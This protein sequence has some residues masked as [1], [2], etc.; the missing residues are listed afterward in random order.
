MVAVNKAS[1]NGATKTSSHG[2]GVAAPNNTNT[3]TTV[4][5]ISTKP[6]P[7]GITDLFLTK[8]TYQH[9][10]NDFHLF[11]QHDF[12]CLIHYFTTTLGVWG[13]MHLM[14]DLLNRHYTSTAT[15]T[16]DV[17]LYA[18]YAYMILI[19][20]TTPIM[21]AVIH[22]AMIYGCLQ[23][24]P[25][26][27]LTYVT[28]KYGTQLL[29]L[30]N[31]TVE[32][33]HIAIA[34]IVL[35]YG[36]QDLSHYLCDEPTFMS[37]YMKQGK[38]WMLIVH[39]IWLLPLVIDSILMRHCYLPYLVTRNRNVV[40][41]S[42]ASRD[43]VEGLRDW[44]H[45]N[46]P[47]TPETTHVWPHNQVP[48]SK[49]TVALENDAAI[50]AA[51]RTVF[52]KKHYD[53]VPVQSMN[54]IYVTAVGAKKSINS[55]A[56]FYTPHTDGPYWFLPYASLYR[57]LVGVTHNSMV[58]TRFNLQH[59]TQDQVLDMYGVVGFDYNRELHWID[60]V[61]NAKNEERRSLLKLHFVV[62]P[63]GWH[64]YG[65]LCAYL[66]TSYNT[67]ARGNFLTTLRPA[68]SY[69]IIMAW[70]IWLT[71][72]GNAEFVELIGWDNLVYIG[73]CSTLLGPIPFLI[74]TSFRHYA[75]YMTTFA[76]REPMVA[77]GYLMRDAKLYKTISMLHLAKRLLP[78]VQLPRDI[79]GLAVCIVG[80][81]LTLLATVRLGMVRTY[82]GTEL[83]FVE[84]KWI[85]GFPYGTIPHPMIVGQIFAFATIMY[86]WWNEMT[87]ENKMLLAAHISC[88]TVHMV[89]EEL[90]GGY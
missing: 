30:T 55:D 22:T 40:I 63:K 68:G 7:C 79:V 47:V 51:F 28:A 36:L 39:S 89:Q 3:P 19:G 32:S 24:T 78:M 21:T 46:V 13:A 84:P 35:G 58:R 85:D 52:P 82:F 12:N 33:W 45:T 10:S 90:T 20:L 67:W 81:S 1:M 8:Q 29:S 37:S 2:T 49:A 87:V 75:I 72:K 17:G 44:I 76:Y 4:V 50:E 61:P 48:T 77:H 59:S 5:G 18:V 62:Y 80:F 53:V 88:Y 60:H 31:L 54:E 66:N 38:A 69:E 65:K 43:A 41:S 16:D 86:W 14:M 70:W 15:V 73:V 27:V 6:M 42:V 34:A 74:L 64:T 71:T 11:H 25:A 56:V 83:K 23:V 26:D 57:V 9:V